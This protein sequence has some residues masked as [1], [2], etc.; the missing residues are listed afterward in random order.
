MEKSEGSLAAGRGLAVCTSPPGQVELGV[1]L[2][3]SRHWHVFENLQS[4]EEI[5]ISMKMSERHNDGMSVCTK[6]EQT[7]MLILILGEYNLCLDIKWKFGRN[8]TKA[9]KHEFGETDYAIIVI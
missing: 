7:E 8:T 6:I 2:P 3:S 1:A 5:Q 9:L 4:Q